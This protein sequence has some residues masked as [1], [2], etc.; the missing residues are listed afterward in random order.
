[1]IVDFIAV[2]GK[3]KVELLTFSFGLRISKHKSKCTWQNAGKDT[4]IKRV[5]KRNG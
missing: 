4:I 2:D 3:K 1:L 5:N